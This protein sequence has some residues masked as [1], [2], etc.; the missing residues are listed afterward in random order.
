MAIALRSQ[1]FTGYGT[2][3]N[4]TI[5]APSGITDGDI[6]V[7]SITTVK[8]A[9]ETPPTP[10]LTGFTLIGTPTTIDAGGVTMRLFRLWK[11]AASESGDYTFTHTSADS[12]GLLQCF[13]GCLA[14]GAPLTTES[15][16]TGNSSTA[17][18]TGITTT[19][20][21]SWLLYTMSCY[22]FLGDLTV[23]TGMTEQHDSGSSITYSATEL[24]AAAGATGNRTQTITSS[25]WSVGMT[26]LLAA[27]AAATDDGAAARSGSTFLLM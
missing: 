16:N 25:P 24:I 21:N 14:S 26:E 12:D 27:A 9:G 1:A 22:D 13:S 19:A 6:L 15:I 3:T 8:G 17:T 2:R 11:R 20:A 7:A 23:P 18:G 5:T 4:I 10:S